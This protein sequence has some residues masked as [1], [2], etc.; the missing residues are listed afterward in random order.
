MSH[1]VVPL[2]IYYLIFATLILLTLITVEVAFWNLGILT[3]WVAM[4]IA[5]SKASL[6]VL[7][8]MH[9][10]YAHPLT[11]L[12]VAAGFVFLAILVVFTLSDTLTR[13]WQFQIKQPGISFLL[14][15]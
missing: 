6:V 7:Y 8:F 11:W 10:R 2:R 13:G 12:F 15:P 14:L 3:F 1:N 9:V 5:S 4:A